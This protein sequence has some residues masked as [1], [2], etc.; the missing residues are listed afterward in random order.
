MRSCGISKLYHFEFAQNSLLVQSFNLPRAPA[1][2]AYKLARTGYLF[3]T[4]FVANRYSYNSVAYFKAI[5]CVG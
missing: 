4:E 2:I 5:F 3:S 1:I